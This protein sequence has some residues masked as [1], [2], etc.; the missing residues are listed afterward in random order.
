MYAPPRP[1]GLCRPNPFTADPLSQLCVACRVFGNPWLPAPVVCSDF[2]AKVVTS[3][4]IRA[5][6]SDDFIRMVRTHVGI[7]R[8]LGTA[9]EGRLYSTAIPGRFVGEGQVVYSGEL[10]GELAE[11]DLGMLLIVMKSVAFIGGGKNHGLGAVTVNITTLQLEDEP[12]LSGDEAQ[13]K[14]LVIAETALLG[15]R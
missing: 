2:V 7:S 10:S 15:R 6:E 9:Q 11:E 4:D 14:G 12:P 3:T 5:A 8:Q 1:D 13:S